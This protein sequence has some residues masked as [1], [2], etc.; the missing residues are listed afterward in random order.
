LITRLLTIGMLL[1]AGVCQAGLQQIH[2]EYRFGH[3]VNTFCSGEPEQCYWLINT[4]AETRQELKRQVADHPP[5]TPICLT[6]IA[7]LSTE[8]TDGFGADYDGSIRVQ[9]VIGRCH[10]EA[11]LMDITLKELR[12][13]RWVL[14]RING[15]E[16]AEYAIQLGFDAGAPPKIIPDL[17]FGE[18]N[19]LSGNTACNR[20]STQVTVQSNSLA[21]A[22]IASTR[23]ACPGFPGELERQLLL[24]YA[25]TLRVSFD[26]TDLLLS[27]G[28]TE[29]RYRL[30]DWVN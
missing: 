11:P 26:D 2:G 23:M 22:P 12:H 7:E 21:M 9:Q 17:D 13:H 6:L 8:K 30:K 18:Q 20:F 5:Y 16:L 29:L 24:L 15:L 19:H 14:N 1:L 25:N 10:G 28:V 3:E 27:D 4:R